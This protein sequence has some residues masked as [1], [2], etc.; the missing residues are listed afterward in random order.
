MALASPSARSAR[1]H[2]PSLQPTS[3][4]ALSRVGLRPPWSMGC[5]VALQGSGAVADAKPCPA[6]DR[7]LEVNVR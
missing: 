1:A 3:R 5:A 7:M 4:G 2:L 6:S